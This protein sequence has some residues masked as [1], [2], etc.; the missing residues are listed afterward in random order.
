M[1]DDFDTARSTADAFDQMI[2]G[3]SLS[4]VTG[5]TDLLS[6]GTRQIFGTLEITISKSSDGEW[7]RSDVMIFSKDLGDVSS[8]GTSGRLVS[9]FLLSFQR[10]IDDFSP[11]RTSSTS[12]MQDS[13]LFCISTQISES[14]YFVRFW[15]H[16]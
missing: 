12:C 13:Q 11:V 15:H 8:A 14:F 7:N 4:N 9:L 3:V 5:Y 6:L 2:D 10:Y 16:K 1:L